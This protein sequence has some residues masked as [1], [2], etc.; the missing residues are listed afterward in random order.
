[1]FSVGC[2]LY[3]GDVTSLVK[4]S[5]NETS[6][7]NSHNQGKDLLR[8][9]ESSVGLNDKRQTGNMRG[10]QIWEERLQDKLHYCIFTIF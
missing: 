9:Y 2:E 4:P 1:M 7:P 3:L 6:T 5:T 8:K 10:K